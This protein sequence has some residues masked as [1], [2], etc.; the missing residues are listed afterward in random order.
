MSLP[1]TEALLE[2]A[3]G[4]ENAPYDALPALGQLAFEPLPPSAYWSVWLVTGGFAPGVQDSVAAEYGSE[5]GGALFVPLGAG[6]QPPTRTLPWFSLAALKTASVPLSWPNASAPP[7]SSPSNA[8]VLQARPTP[9]RVR[10][11]PRI[12]GRC[13]N[14][15]PRCIGRRTTH[16]T[17]K[18]G[19]IR[20]K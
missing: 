17:P 19:S 5:V 15:V 6:T 11:G 3:A 13:K 12:R 2:P 18:R 10:C 8:R 14:I 1:M 9:V 16:H 7:A 20:L 4:V